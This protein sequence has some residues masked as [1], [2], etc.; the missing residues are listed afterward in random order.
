M[1]L[2][3]SEKA[4]GACAGHSSFSSGLRGVGASRG[5]IRCSCRLNGEV[6]GHG[7][8]PV[9]MMTMEDDVGK[10]T[11]EI[12]GVRGFRAKYPPRRDG[13]AVEHGADTST[14]AHPDATSDQRP[15]SAGIKSNR[16]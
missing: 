13:N 10:A 16:L 3:H 5:E 6:R 15:K 11:N 9:V 8:E 1:P 14:T 2:I 4:L 12:V 7:F